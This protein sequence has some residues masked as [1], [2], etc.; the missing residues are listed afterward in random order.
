MLIPHLLLSAALFALVSAQKLNQH[1]KHRHHP[2]RAFTYKNVKLVPNAGYYA[3][4]FDVSGISVPTA[5]YFHIDRKALLS[6][7]DCFCAGDFFAVYDGGVIINE[8]SAPSITNCYLF[9][10]DPNVCFFD[11]EKSWSTATS[12]LNVGFH[13]I[14][15]LPLV[16][17]YGK[18][19]AFL[20]VDDSCFTDLAPSIQICCR[21]D[22]SCQVNTVN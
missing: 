19:T 22:N 2:S 6:V 17:P 11:S 12:S 16:T 20:R 15:L 5:F 1:D 14:T 3:F 4:N 18:G 21:L 8:T 9:S 13:N 7:F 10:A